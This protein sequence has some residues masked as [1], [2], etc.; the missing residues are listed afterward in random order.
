MHDG[1]L[2]VKFCVIIK[3]CRHSA[4]GVVFVRILVGTNLLNIFFKKKNECEI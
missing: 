3:E 4:F 1:M 2:I